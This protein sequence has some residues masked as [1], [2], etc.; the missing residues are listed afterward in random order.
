[1]MRVIVGGIGVNRRG[2][3]SRTLGTVRGVKCLRLS[4]EMLVILVIVFVIFAGGRISSMVRMP[5]FVAAMLLA[6]KLNV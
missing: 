1:M 5:M 2:G 4:L 3:C 6:G